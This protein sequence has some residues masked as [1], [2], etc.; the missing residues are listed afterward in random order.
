MND[1]QPKLFMRF[2]AALIVAFTIFSFHLQAQQQSDAAAPSRDVVLVLP[3]ENTSTAAEYH[4]VGG[5]FADALSDLLTVPGL[6]VIS[7]DERELIY[8]RLQLPL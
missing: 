3:F 5:S 4:W 8:Q 7:S 2:L 6:M 1:C